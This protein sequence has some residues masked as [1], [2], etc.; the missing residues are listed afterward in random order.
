MCYGQ[1][2]RFSDIWIYIPIF[3]II[4]TMEFHKSYA[5]QGKHNLIIHTGTAMAM[6]LYICMLWQKVSS[7]QCLDFFMQCTANSGITSRNT[8]EIYI[9]DPPSQKMHSGDVWWLNDKQLWK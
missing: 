1:H 7:I 9:I 6:Y 5:T 2:L 3:E 8:C 4:E